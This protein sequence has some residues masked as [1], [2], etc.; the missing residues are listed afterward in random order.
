MTIDQAVN[1]AISWLRKA[2]LVILL[3][4]LAVI[5]LKTFGV[6]LPIRT[7]GHVELAYLAGSYW[8]TK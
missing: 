3:A 4:S 1:Q 2:V 6:S 5:L 7:L 8:L